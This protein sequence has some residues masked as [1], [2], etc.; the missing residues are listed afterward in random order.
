[1]AVPKSKT[2]KSKRNMRRSHHA[3]KNVNVSV[4][5]K[6]E[7]V[8]SHHISADGFY[9]GRNIFAKPEATA[10][11]AAKPEK[12]AEAKEA[13]QKEAEPKA[14]EKTPDASVDAK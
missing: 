10:I 4:D 13:A 9:K 2:S 6:G 14:A 1:M 12:K 8:L 11:E 3:L 5:H 7:A